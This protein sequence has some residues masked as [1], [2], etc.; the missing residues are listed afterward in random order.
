MLA[1]FFI[2]GKEINLILLSALLTIAGY[3]LTD[4]VVVFDRVRENLKKYLRERLRLL[5]TAA[6]T[7]YCHAPSLPL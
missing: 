5:S 3:S 1:V 4:T 2:M 6:S 7:K